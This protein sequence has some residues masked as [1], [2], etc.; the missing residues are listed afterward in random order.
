MIVSHWFFYLFRYLYHTHLKMKD[1]SK[2]SNAVFFSASYP[3]KTVTDGARL[4]LWSYYLN[5]VD[6]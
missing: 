3:I 1:H 6:K 2:M 5:A 4:K